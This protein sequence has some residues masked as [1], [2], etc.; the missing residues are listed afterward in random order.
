MHANIK[1][2]AGQLGKSVNGYIAD[3]LAADVHH[4]VKK[5]SSQDKIEQELMKHITT[6][7]YPM[8]ISQAM[9]QFHLT[10][11][12]VY[13]RYKHLTI[14]DKKLEQA[15]ATAKDFE[16]KTALAD[17]WGDDGAATKA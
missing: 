16:K 14:G 13:N 15:K 9:A 5:S 11:Q 10:Y 17:V 3:L 7:G 8:T 1:K 6:H 12:Q 4:V 2:K